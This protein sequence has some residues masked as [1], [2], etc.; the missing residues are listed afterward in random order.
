ML[1][2]GHR[3][4][5]FVDEEELQ[6]V[7]E[8][9]KE[10][11][12]FRSTSA[13]MFF[14]EKLVELREE[15]GF[16]KYFEVNQQPGDVIFVPPGWFRVSLSLADSISYY[17]QL[18]YQPRVVES[19][20][21]NT[22]YNPWR[23]QWNLAFCYEPDEVV[24][25][26][27]DQVALQTDRIEEDSY[28][29]IESQMKEMTDDRYPMPVMNVLTTCAK[30]L[31]NKKRMSKII[32]IS[33]TKCSDEIWKSCRKQLMNKMSKKK[34]LKWEW[35]PESITENKSKKETESESKKEEL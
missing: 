31:G 35:L 9:A 32:E 24:S 14:E 28:K 25:K 26:L 19:I 6:A 20:V 5:L 18:L 11:L 8:K 2:H 4:Y 21:R 23:R 27:K 13:Y 22:V 29:W 1:I 17:E 30:I 7:G 16:K 10:A 34:S 15:F 33:K 3:R 12:E